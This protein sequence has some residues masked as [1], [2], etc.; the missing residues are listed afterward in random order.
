M[1]KATIRLTRSL[2]KKDSSFITI[3]YG[4]GVTSEDA[5]KMVDA[6]KEKIPEEIDVSLVEG[7]QPV[8]YYIISVE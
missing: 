3:L 5:E 7:K 2:I 6:L 4:E 8:Y 1:E